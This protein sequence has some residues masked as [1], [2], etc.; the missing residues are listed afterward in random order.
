MRLARVLVPVNFTNEPRF[1]H[2]PAYA[3]PPLPALAH[4][5]EFTSADAA[6]KGFVRAQMVRGQNR[7]VAAMRAAGRIV[8]AALA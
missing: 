4:A 8:D 3:C 5:R 7:F 1:R 2:D 6:R